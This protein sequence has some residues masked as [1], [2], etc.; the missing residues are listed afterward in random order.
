MLIEFKI[1]NFRSF[2]DEATLSMIAGSKK[3]NIENVVFLDGVSILNSACIFGPNAAG[4]S[5]LLK[6]LAASINYIRNSVYFH[7]DDPIP[8]MDS[9]AFDDE[10]LKNPSIFEYTFITQSN[11]KY[12][13][14][15]SCNHKK[16][17]FEE[18]LAYKSQK[19]TTIFRR[20][21]DSY[22]FPIRES[23]KQMENIKSYNFENKLFLS[24][25]AQ[26]NC[27]EVLD[28]YDWFQHYVNVWIPGHPD[29][30]DF[31][32]DILES[33]EGEDFR[34]FAN[35]LLKVADLNIDYLTFE[36]TKI[37][38]LNPNDLKETGV[39]EWAFNS[40]NKS[41]T[42]KTTHKI[43]QGK[44]YKNYDLSF[45]HE[46]NGTQLLFWFSGWLYTA[47]KHG[48][49]VCIDEFGTSLHPELA[50][51]LISLFNDN[52]INPNHAQLIITTHILELLDLSI[53][54]RDQI[55]F[56]SKNNVGSSELYSLDDYSVRSGENILKNYNYG[57]YGAFPGISHDW[58]DYAI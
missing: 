55:Y 48:I 17:L 13:Y 30:I 3:E 9:F 39:S 45:V 10:S 37:Q 44:S 12:I 36:E 41:Y 6:A 38:N 11:N 8:S 18:L 19:P 35:R 51:Y 15:F 43:K 46:S 49:C 33:D 14:K 27:S 50:K 21:K 25:A 28:A 34:K 32:I 31:T 47:F 57:R 52:V 20:D 53:L 56:V 2:K 42:I 26:W 7:K 1:Q 16:V 24:T 5:N 22:D 40:R 54:R 58:G 4:K 23:K 29:N